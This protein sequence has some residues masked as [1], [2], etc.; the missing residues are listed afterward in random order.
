MTTTE[1]G[2]VVFFWVYTPVFVR[3]CVCQWLWGLPREGRVMRP[4]GG[5]SVELM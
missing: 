4:V 5:C 3:M 1:S 2:V